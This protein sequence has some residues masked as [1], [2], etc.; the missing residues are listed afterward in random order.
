MGHFLSRSSPERQIFVLRQ[1]L[2]SISKPVSSSR[3]ALRLR[4]R[5]Q[6]LSRLAV[7]PTL[8]QAPP[9][10]RPHLD[11]FEHD[12][13]FGAI[14]MTIRGEPAFGRGLVA[15]QPLYSV[16]PRTRTM[17]QSCASA[18]KLLGGGPI[19]ETGFK[20]MACLGDRHLGSSSDTDDV[21]LVSLRELGFSKSSPSRRSQYD[22]SRNLASGY[23][24]PQGN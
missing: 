17:M 24:T 2:C 21:L 15:P 11:S 7:A 6:K 22:A 16:G 10:T 4:R 19:L 20:T 18:A 8:R 1:F 9:V 14:G 5:A 12:G 3:P 23:Q 13:T